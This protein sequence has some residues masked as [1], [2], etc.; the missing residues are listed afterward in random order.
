MEALPLLAAVAFLVVAGIAAVVGLSRTKDVRRFSEPVRS[1]LR[2]AGLELLELRQAGWLEG[3]SSQWWTADGR[4][5]EVPSFGQVHIGHHHDH[6]H[7]IVC[8]ATVRVRDGGSHEVWVRITMHHGTAEQ[9]A[10]GLPLDRI[11]D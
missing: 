4:H 9:V 8:R 10:F 11:G 2:S 6:E 7:H 3:G 5:L 1:A